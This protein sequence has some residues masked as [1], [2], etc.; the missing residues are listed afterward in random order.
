MEKIEELADEV[1]N[2]LSY[3]CINECKAFCCRDGNLIVNNDELDLISGN[4][5]TKKKLISES[6]IEMKMFGKNLLTFK[7]SCDG[8]PA[9]RENKCLIHK[10]ILR[11][12]TCKDF[13]IF[14]VGNEIKI[15]SRCPAKSEGKFFEFEKKALGLGYIIVDKF[16]FQ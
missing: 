13:P 16:S 9:L 4:E 12:K 5:H 10:N 1:R 6:S 3:F 2:G 11:P 7:N 8:C 15:S 14:I